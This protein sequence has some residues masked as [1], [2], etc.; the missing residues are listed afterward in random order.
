MK[1]RSEH[2]IDGESCESPRSRARRSPGGGI[3][4]F[5][6]TALIKIAT[7]KVSEFLKTQVHEDPVAAALVLRG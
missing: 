2:A 1:K 4:N 7:L 3:P 6:E 5:E